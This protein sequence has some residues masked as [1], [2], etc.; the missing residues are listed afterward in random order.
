MMRSSF[1][2]FRQYRAYLCC[3]ARGEELVRMFIGTGPER[4]AR[5]F[6]LF[7]RM[8]TPSAI[9]AAESGGPGT[10]RFRATPD[11]GAA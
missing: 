3:Y 9:L 1:R 10:G 7:T 11:S 6:G 2:F 8:L 4:A 5:Y